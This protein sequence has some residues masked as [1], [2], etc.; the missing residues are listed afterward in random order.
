M[1]KI[2]VGSWRRA[3]L[4]LG[5]ATLLL[6]GCAVAPLEP[7]AVGTPV[8]SYPAPIYGAPYAPPVYPAYPVYPAPYYY[9]PSLS[10]GVYGGWYRDRRDW[11][12]PPPRRD[13]HGRPGPRPGWSGHPG[14]GPRPGWSGHP[15]P[16]PGSSGRPPGPRPGAG[17][18][19]PRPQGPRVPPRMPFSG[20]DGEGG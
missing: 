20:A 8:T 15:S 5:G 6:G 18:P 12:G 9:G 1:K 7:Y 16:R 10:L 2:Q 3:R 11:H 13:W 17:S 14:P 4:L 19:P